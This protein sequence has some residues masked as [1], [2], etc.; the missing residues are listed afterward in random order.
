MKW[1]EK[2]KLGYYAQDHAEDFASGEN[3]TDWISGYVREGRL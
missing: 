3:L 2:A 1:A